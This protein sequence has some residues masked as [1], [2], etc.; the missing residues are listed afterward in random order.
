MFDRRLVEDYFLK[1]AEEIKNEDIIERDIKIDII[2]GKAISI[3]GPRRAGKTYLMKFISKQTQEYFFI[4]LEHIAFLKVEPE[5]VF[6]IISIYSEIFLKEPKILFLDEIQNLKN[7]ESV[8]RSLIDSGYIPIISG[9]SSKLLSKEIATQ[10]GGRSLTYYVFPFSFKEFLKLKGIEVRKYITLEEEGKI[11][12]LLKNYILSTSY[13]EI[14]ITGNY[15]L[16]SEYY[17]SIFYR[18]FVE[19]FKLKSYEIARFIFNFFLQ[20]FSSEISINKIVNFLKSQGLKFGKNTVYKY[21]EKLPETLNVFLVDKLEKGAYKSW[22]KKAYICDLGLVNLVKV[23]EENLGRRMENLVF[24]ELMRR[25]NIY[26]L[27][28]IY[29]FKDYQQREVDFVIKEGLNIKQLIQVTYANSKDEIERREIKSLLKAYDLFK[30]FNPELI[31]ITWDYEDTL[32]IDNKEIKFIP[33]WKWL[34]LS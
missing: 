6:K 5:D 14:L 27:L 23:S 1:K 11:K 19:R 13:P 20:N 10:L 32:K 15:K 4:D 2:K 16:L 26:P 28:E 25:K 3:V 21:V 22:V 17:N 8:V 34:L 30:E 9:S 7:W 29:Y 18:D 33:L 31:I 12:G 24:L